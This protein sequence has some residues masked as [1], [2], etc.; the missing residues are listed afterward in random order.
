VDQWYNSQECGNALAD[1]LFG[2]VSPSGK[3]PT[4]FPRRLEDNPAFINYPG[5]N[6][7]VLYGEGLFVGYRYYDKKE[8][9]PLFPF[10]Y[11]LSYTT[12]EYRNLQVSNERFMAGEGVEVQV[13]IH[14]NGSRAGKEIVQLYVHDYHSTLVRPEKELKA[15][16]KVSLEPGQSQ[17]VTF[18]LDQEAFWYYDPAKGGWQTEPGAFEI[19]VGASSRDIRLRGTVELVVGEGEGR[20]HRGLP[21]RELLAN[22]RSHAVLKR[23]FGEMLNA[24]A[25]LGV[26]DQTLE[27]LAK[28]APDILTAEKMDEIE[29]EM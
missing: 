13:E 12:F 6:G 5:E 18:R 23:H 27:Q 3:L 16:T 7:Q 14:N 15:F 8:L 25:L 28:L 11:G 29:A 9:E 22:E 4:T 2:D 21:L 20:L 26:L 19:L 17:T 10:G 24:P 1:I